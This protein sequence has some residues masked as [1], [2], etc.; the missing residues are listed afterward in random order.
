MQETGLTDQESGLLS[1][2]ALHG[3]AISRRQSAGENQA[4]WQI[5]F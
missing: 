2:A 3:V 4:W 5:D 1:M